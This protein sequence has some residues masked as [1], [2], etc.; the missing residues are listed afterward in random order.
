MKGFEGLDGTAAG[1]EGNAEDGTVVEVGRC[2]A[3]DSGI[4]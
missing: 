4:I 1:K 2:T 3:V